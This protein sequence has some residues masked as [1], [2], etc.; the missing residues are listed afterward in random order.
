MLKVAVSLSALVHGLLFTMLYL[1]PEGVLVGAQKGGA[2]SVF[3][4]I[5]KKSLPPAP[6]RGKTKLSTPRSIKKTNRIFKSVKVTQKPVVAKKTLLTSPRPKGSGF[7]LRNLQSHLSPAMQK[8][9]LQL[10][11]DIEKNKHYPKKAKR[12]RQRGEVA[13]KFSVTRA[14]QVVD[15]VVDTPSPFQTLNASA[16][17]AVLSL[18]ENRYPLP[19]EVTSSQI[20]VILPIRYNL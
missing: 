3:V 7:D 13:I 1:C 11:K 4:E 12:F 9:L 8:F 14:G 18:K 15:V 6:V 2:D 20:Q 17:K 5:Q 16:R 10:R 19:V